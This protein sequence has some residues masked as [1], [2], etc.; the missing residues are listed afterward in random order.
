MSTSGMS[1]RVVLV[2][3]DVSEERIASIFR[4]KNQRTKNT[5]AVVS[6]CSTLQRSNHYMRK[7]EI[8][9]NILHCGRERVL[10]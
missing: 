3:T 2:R 7:E 10:L 6:D 9:W 5:L 1:R 8:E 4:V